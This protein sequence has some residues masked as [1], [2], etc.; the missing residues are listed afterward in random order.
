MLFVF[1]F[2]FLV[3]N[4]GENL[5]PP[6]PLV[7][8]PKVLASSSH[9]VT[10]TPAAAAVAARAALRGV[11]DVSARRDTGCSVTSLSVV[12]YIS[13]RASELALMMSSRGGY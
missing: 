3:R 5:P 13:E 8:P 6:L 1:V 7:P 4:R 12:V 2:F 9:A 10:V 11:S